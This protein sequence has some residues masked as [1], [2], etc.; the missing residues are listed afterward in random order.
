MHVRRATIRPVPVLLRDPDMGRATELATQL[1]LKGFATRIASTGASA[2]SAIKEGHF[3]TLIV[4]A[5]LDDTACLDWLDDLRRTA[6]R[7]WMIVVSP[8]C[9]TQTCK[10]IYLHGG[11]ACVT[12]RY[13]SMI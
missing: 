5:D 12:A 13:Q 1:A 2:Q 8:R 9:D 11:D 7:S 10:L 4:I 6:S 3:A